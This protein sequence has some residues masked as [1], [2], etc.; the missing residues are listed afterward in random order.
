MYAHQQGTIK[1][2][3]NCDNCDCGDNCRCIPQQFAPGCR[4]KTQGCTQAQ[5][6]SYPVGGAQEFE[7]APQQGYYHV[8]APVGG[9]Q[10]FQAAPQQGCYHVQAPVGNFQ[11]RPSYP[12]YSTVHQYGAPRVSYSPRVSHAHGHCFGAG[13]ARVSI[14]APRY[15][16]Y[17]RAVTTPV[18]TVTTPVRTLGMAPIQMR[19]VAA[20]APVQV[21]AVAAPVVTYVAPV[22][23]Q[24]T[25]EPA[26]D[27][28]KFLSFL[29]FF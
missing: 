6:Q 22:V 28:S 24:E 18:R 9:A 11:A 25:E 17:A 23:S 8:Q 10:E 21:R 26:E 7:A 14:A 12:A 5:P 3:C 2:G 16:G 19:A 1:Y 13:P 27:E 29:N 4:V 20:P 15:G